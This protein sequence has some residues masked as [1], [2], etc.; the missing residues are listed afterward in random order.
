METILLGRFYVDDLPDHLLRL[1]D[2]VEQ[3]PFGFVED[4]DASNFEVSPLAHGGGRPSYEAAAT[5]VANVFSGRAEPAFF[6]VLFD[7]SSAFVSL[8]M[9]GTAEVYYFEDLFFLDV[10]PVSEPNLREVN[11]FLLED[12]GL[13]VYEE[14]DAPRSSGYALVRCSFEP[15]RLRA[16]N[17]DDLLSQVS[18]GR[19]RFERSRRPWDGDRTKGLL[20]KIAAP[21]PFLLDKPPSLAL[22]KRLWSGS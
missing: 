3:L 11:R 22:L 17:L 5:A 9:G 16:R 15:V 12:G 7:A 1:V 10:D 21:N 6:C 4:P 8:F 20:E 19:Y 13:W 2:H 18:E 14:R